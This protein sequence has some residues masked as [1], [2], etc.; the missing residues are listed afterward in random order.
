MHDEL[1]KPFA[2]ISVKQNGGAAGHNGIRSITAEL[3]TNEYRRLRLGIGRPTHLDVSGYV[4]SAM[5]S[6]ELEQLSD[7]FSMICNN[8]ILV[9]ERKEAEFL[10]KATL[11]TK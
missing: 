1:E 3:G 5:K 9:I 6:A 11:V 4:L 7:I 8:L 2:A 10:A